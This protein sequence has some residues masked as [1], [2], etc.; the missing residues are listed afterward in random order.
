[1]RQA[2]NRVLEQLPEVEIVAECADGEDLLAAI[3]RAHPDVV[4]TDVRMPPSGDDEGI[5]IA[6]QLRQ[7]HPHVGV[8]VL[9]QL[10]EPRYG[11][12]LLADGAEGRAYLLKDRVGEPR[13]LLT[14]I[15]VVARGGSLIDP[16]MVRLLV[17]AGERRQE[18]PLSALTPRE[19]EVLAEMAKGASNAA[20]AERLVLSKRAVEKYVGAIF[21]KLGLPD[22]HEVSRRVAA[23]LVLLAEEPLS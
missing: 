16:V 13:E 21:S 2:I 3:A 20:I 5:R 23:V 8:V 10:A 17:A 7:T 14:A 12:D 4:L 6:R 11:I 9:S 18:S 1:M 22:E 15:E 19:R